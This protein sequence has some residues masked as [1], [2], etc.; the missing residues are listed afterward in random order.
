MATRKTG[1]SRDLII[2]PGET[3]ADILEERGISQAELAARMGVTPAYISNVISGKKDISAKFAQ[4]LEYAL[5]VPKT[6]WL[7]LQAHY[8]AELLEY[9]KENTITD[10]EKKARDSLKE[11]VKYLRRNG[12]MLP[13]ESVNDSILSLRSV[14]QVSNL[15]NLKNVVPDGCFRMSPSASVDPY[16]IGAWL[17]L[18]DIMADNRQIDSKFA[19]DKVTDLIIELKNVMTRE[20]ANVVTDIREI[21]RNYGIDFSVVHNF[22]GAPVHGYIS[23][24]R[25]GTYH[26][27]LTIRGAY[28]D[29]FWFSLFHELGHI[30]NGD[31]RKTGS[32]I[33]SGI[34][35]EAE[36][37]ADLFASNCLLD[38]EDYQI[39][40][41]TG[42]FDIN[43]ICSFSRMQNVRPYIV[44][45]RLQKE[46][47]IRYNQF[48]NYKIR[49]K[50]ADSMSR[51]TLLS[52][53]TAN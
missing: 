33:D 18:C 45:G 15:A 48:S 36:R 53:K 10:E 4:K 31:V 37:K 43:S 46:G 42:N 44:I 38:F 2:H 41:K 6:F 1:I 49:Y 27:V 28:A 19:A 14:L 39:F 8:D 30:V 52:A 32:F 47:K 7:H 26:M 51:G 24:K 50:W 35:Q 23:K 29:I 17:R 40:I 20:Q 5:G 3:I 16:V 25:D 34:D 22:R 13:R 11:I 21:M 12:K 9:E